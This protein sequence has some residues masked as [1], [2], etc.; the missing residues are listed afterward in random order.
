MKDA[1]SPAQRSALEADL[2][3]GAAMR[4]PACGAALS[5]SPVEAPGE[6]AYVRSRVLVICPGCRRSA[7]LDRKR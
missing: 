7:S 2:A 1:W 3:R 4:C 5:V 6:V